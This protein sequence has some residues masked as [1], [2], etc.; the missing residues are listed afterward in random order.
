MPS[1][2]MA[3]GTHISGGMAGAAVRRKVAGWCRVS[4]QSTEYL[5]IGML[6]TP[7]MAS[8]AQARPAVSGRGTACRNAYRAMYR[9][10]STSMEVVRASHTHQAPQVGL[11]QAA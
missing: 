9:N 3:S 11:P 5:M 10:S 2:L 1:A 4:H 7:T 6:I 8:T